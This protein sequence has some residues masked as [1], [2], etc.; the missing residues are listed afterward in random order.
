MKIEYYIRTMDTFVIR[1]YSTIIIRNLPF[2][3]RTFRGNVLIVIFEARQ[4][5]T[6][7]THHDSSY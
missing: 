7:V 5:P 3:I 1:A 6:I 2:I 4:A